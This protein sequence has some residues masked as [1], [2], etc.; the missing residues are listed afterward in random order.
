MYLIILLQSILFLPE[1]TFF[2]LAM[3]IIGKLTVELM[4]PVFKTLQAIGKGFE[5]VKLI[6]WLL[7]T[8]FSPIGNTPK[9]L[10]Y[11]NHNMFLH[12]N[13]VI[14]YR[15]VSLPVQG[16]HAMAHASIDIP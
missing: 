12:L 9:I 15:T 1:K 3:F 4:Q 10:K 6:F 13:S 11:L 16:P 2:L 7:T 5:C 8:E 14:F